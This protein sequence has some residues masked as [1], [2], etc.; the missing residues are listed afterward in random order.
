MHPLP[1]QRG[2]EVSPEV[3]DG[4]QSVVYQQAENKLHVIK[5]ILAL[6]IK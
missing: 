5:A 2:V 4:K 3:I 6:L 1:A